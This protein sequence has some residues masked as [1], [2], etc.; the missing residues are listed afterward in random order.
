MQMTGARGLW[1]VARL[2]A[3]FGGGSKVL[4]FAGAG[5]DDVIVAAVAAWQHSTGQL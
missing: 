2:C 5:A 1:I 4:Y 3:C